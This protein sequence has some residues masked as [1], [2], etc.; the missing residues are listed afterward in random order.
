[1]ALKHAK[2]IREAQRIA[3]WQYVQS[4]LVGVGNLMFTWSGIERQINTLICAYHHDAPEKLRAR[5][6]PSNIGEKVKYLVE[7]GRDERLPSQLRRAISG[8]VPELNR[9]CRHRHLIAHGMVFQRNRNS[10]EWYVQELVL[11]GDMPVYKE[12]FF[13]P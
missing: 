9:L 13:I 11:K 12:H 4:V 8:W 5:G 1:L 2:K 7:V 10:T 3:Q 6:L